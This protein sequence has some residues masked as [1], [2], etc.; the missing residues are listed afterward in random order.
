ML[1]VYYRVRELSAE[2]LAIDNALFERVGEE[3]KLP[4]R[5]KTT[6]QDLYLQV[7]AELE[8]Q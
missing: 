2:G 1:D 3:L 4:A 6:I 8:P 7:K 5:G